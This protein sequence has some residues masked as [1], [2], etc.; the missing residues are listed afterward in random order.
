MFILLIKISVSLVSEIL[1]YC[2]VQKI[3]V[4]YCDA[5][6]PNAYF[7]STFSSH[8]K[9]DSSQRPL[10]PITSFFHFLHSSHRFLPVFMKTL[11]PASYF[12]GIF[13]PV[14]PSFFSFICLSCP[15]SVLKEP[16]RVGMAAWHQLSR[17]PVRPQGCLFGKFGKCFFT[18]KPLSLSSCWD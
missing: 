10:T 14:C 2:T 6:R 4:R 1:V 17:L 13:P 16:P 7:T 12:S 8:W 5:G 15:G 9:M 3:S 18:V 11:P